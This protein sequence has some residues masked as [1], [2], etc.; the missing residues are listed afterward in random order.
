MNVYKPILRDPI[1]GA[2]GV[3]PLDHID[4]HFLCDG[5]TIFTPTD[6]Q[7]SHLMDRA[8]FDLRPVRLASDETVQRVATAN[9]DCFWAISRRPRTT[10]VAPAPGGLVAML[11]LND[12]GIDALITGRL[13]ARDPPSQFLVGQHQ[14]PAAIYGWLEIH[15]KG[16]LAPGLTLVMEK[17]QAPLY[18]GVDIFCRAATKDGA[19]FFDALGFSRGVWWDGEFRSEFRHYRRTHGGAGAS[20]LAQRL[21]PPFD[22]Y[23]PSVTETPS[24]KVQVKVVHSLDEILK[25]FAIR[26]AVYVEEQKCPYGEEFDGN[27]FSGTH[28]L[29]S[30]DDEPAGCLQNPLLCRG[31]PLAED[32]G[33][34]PLELL[35]VLVTREVPHA[36]KI[37]SHP[38]QP[39]EDLQAGRERR[40]PESAVRS[41]NARTVQALSEIEIAEAAYGPTG[42]SRC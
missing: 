11:M 39:S 20:V 41:Q 12:A 15:A 27:D 28:L 16:R 37:K 33:D 23:G 22:D 25:T 2:V 19:A 34:N 3:H 5:V 18:R 36:G 35:R 1:D 8:R 32:L 9:P 6:Q 14:R 30:I 13:D 42:R 40:C 31:I 38:R 21:R 10:A 24:P 29:A 17:L 4:A 26:S 7:I